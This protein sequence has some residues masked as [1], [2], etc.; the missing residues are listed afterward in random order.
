MLSAE[1]EGDRCRSLLWALEVWRLCPSCWSEAD[2][3]AGGVFVKWVGL[4][5]LGDGEHVEE[6]GEAVQQDG[7]NYV[8]VKASNKHLLFTRLV[9]VE[10]GAVAEESLA[11]RE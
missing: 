7:L 9:W 3:F 1:W 5:L 6:A 8:F 4:F 11:F 10:F 2:G